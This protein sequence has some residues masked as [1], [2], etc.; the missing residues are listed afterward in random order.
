MT[1]LL[2]ISRSLLEKIVII[3][4]TLCIVENLCAWQENVRPKLYVELGKYEILLHYLDEEIYKY[5]AYTH[6]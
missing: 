5:A 4:M 2:I 3:V 6:D 1:R